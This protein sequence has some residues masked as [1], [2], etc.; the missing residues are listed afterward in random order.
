[1]LDGLPVGQISAGALVA[2]VVL[3]ILTGR[4]VPRQQMLDLR[5]DR[6]KWEASATKWQEVASTQGM[7]LERLLEYAETSNHAL[8]EIQSHA[9]MRRPEVEQ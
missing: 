6:D 3:L 2:L 5:A 9:G 1:V 7:T 4:L 8:T